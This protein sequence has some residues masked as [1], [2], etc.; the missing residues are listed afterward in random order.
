M[1]STGLNI[2]ELLKALK[3]RKQ[4]ILKNADFINTFTNLKD[5]IMKRIFFI[6]LILLISFSGINAQEF[7]EWRGKDRTGVY[8]ETG[9][10]KKWKEKGPDLIWSN[11]SIH[12]GYSSVVIAHNTIYTT[13]RDDTLD[14][15]IALDMKGQIKW[16]TAFGRA[17][18]NSYNESRATPTIEGKNIYISSGFGDVAC[19]DAISGKIK[20]KLKASEKFEGTYGRWGLSESLLL[21]DDKVIYTPG[22][23]KTTIIALDKKN[24]ETIWQS[25]SIGDDPSYT[26]PLLIERKGKKQIVTTTKNYIIGVNPEDG[27][28]V[29]KF[30]FGKYAGGKRPYNNQTNTP[31]YYK[32]KIF[33]SSGYDHKAV[34]LNLAKDAS[35]VSIA[36]I[37]S[38]LDIHHGGA[39]R[40]GKYIYGANWHHNRMGHWACLNWETGAVMYETEWENKGSIISADGMLYC[41]E[42]KRGNI[43]LV[44]A[45]PKKFEV[46]SSFKVPLGTGPYWAH[47]MIKNGI[48]YIRHGKAI[49]A[50]DIKTK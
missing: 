30:D 14:V 29:W 17:W 16:Q 7:A 37:D 23:K 10:Q 12:N 39:V 28:I 50:Y 36:W 2:S 49:M 21:V 3:V 18:D 45:D 27:T 19:I 22:G 46:I 48:L 8:N 41:F 38:T 15:L 47:P 4:N 6:S 11:D 42:E 43:A 5:K 34:M 32:G 31:L 26:S 44:K 1:Q 13:G 33:V 35:S 25:K 40:I 9:L 24:G 20:W